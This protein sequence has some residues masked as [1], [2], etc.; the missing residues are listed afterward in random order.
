MKVKIGNWPKT[1]DNRKVDIQIDKWDTWNADGTLA[2]IIYPMLVQLRD[3]KHG[4]P[5]ELVDDVGGEDY[6]NQDSF[7][8]YK[9]THKES[10]E[11]A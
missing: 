4:V 11:I 6:V 1:S 3:T 5:S 9:E 2:M 10:W 8:F 7:D